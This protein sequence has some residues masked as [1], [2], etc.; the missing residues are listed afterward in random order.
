MVVSA[1]ERMVRR[2]PEV[3]E[4]ESPS[5]EQRR[6]D[7]LVGICSAR[8]AADP[9]PD[10]ATVVV[11]VPVQ[12]LMGEGRRSEP[13]CALEGGGVVPTSVARRLACDAQDRDRAHRP[14]AG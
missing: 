5:P 10:R 4:E 7:A 13:G 9:D 14:Q 8:V 12:V 6:A 11:H 1:V 2:L 3:P